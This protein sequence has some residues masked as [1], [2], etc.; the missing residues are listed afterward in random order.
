MNLALRQNLWLADVK[1]RSPYYYFLGALGLKVQDLGLSI[2]DLSIQHVPVN[3]RLTLALEAAPTKRHGPKI[4][5]A[6]RH[7]NPTPGPSGSNTLY[8][9]SWV[10]LAHLVKHAHSNILGLPLWASLYVRK[11]TSPTCLVMSGPGNSRPSWNWPPQ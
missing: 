10:V 11:A 4:E 1:T 3:E 2:L 8:G 7:H 6:G 5:G 9:H